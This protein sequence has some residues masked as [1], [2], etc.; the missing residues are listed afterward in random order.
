MPL[1]AKP[2]WLDENQMDYPAL[3]VLIEIGDITKKSRFDEIVRPFLDKLGIDFLI[4]LVHDY[5]GIQQ[6]VA[7]GLR[8]KGVASHI[9]EAF[10]KMLLSSPGQAPVELVTQTFEYLKGRKIR[11]SALAI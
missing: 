11:Q 8:E 5:R 1:R 2:W 6:N 7:L 3:P 10:N 4:Q 9:A